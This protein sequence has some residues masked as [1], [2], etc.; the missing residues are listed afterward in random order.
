[1]IVRVALAIP[2]LA[3]QMLGEE[4]PLAWQDLSQLLIDYSGYEIFGDKGRYY[5]NRIKQWCGY[6]KRQYPQAETL[7]SNIR[8]LQKADEI[9]NV[10]RQSAHL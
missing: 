6:L 10:L 1:M 5:P 3:R 7:F 2:K 4:S 8:R 9:V